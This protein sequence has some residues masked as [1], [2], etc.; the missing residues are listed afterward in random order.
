MRDGS[1]KITK[2]VE[3]TGMEGEI[4][5]TQDIFYYEMKGGVSYYFSKNFSVLV[6]AGR[7]ITYSDPGTFTKPITGNEF[8]LWQQLTMNNYL[9]QVKFEHRYRV[10]QRWFKTGYRNRY[11]YRLNA[12]VPLGHKKIEPG[13]FY[14]SAFNEVFFT[15]KAPYFERNRFFSGVGYQFNNYITLQPGYVYQFD[16]RN[17]VGAGKHFFQLTLMFDIDGS[18]N[19]YER[20]PTNLD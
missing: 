15:N 13:T 18:K 11:R 2:I 1:R 10:E 6:G 17:S 20:I 16:Y 14:L 12:A 3:I 4:I 8:R 7:Y 9:A 19:P 5:S